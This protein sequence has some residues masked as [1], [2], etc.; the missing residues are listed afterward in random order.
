L[1]TDCGSFGNRTAALLWAVSSFGAFFGRGASR[2]CLVLAQ[3]AMLFA[4]YWF[5]VLPFL[6]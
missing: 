5:Y 4:A 6:Y 2:V 1:P 3:G